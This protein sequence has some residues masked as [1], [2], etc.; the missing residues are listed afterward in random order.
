MSEWLVVGRRRRRA[1]PLR[2]RR[3]GGHLLGAG[4]AGAELEFPGSEMPEPTGTRERVVSGSVSLLLHGGMIALLALAAALAPEEMIEEIIEITRLPDQATEEPAPRPKVLA[5]SSGRFDPAPMAMAPRIVNPAVI[6]RRSNAVEARQLQVDTVS[7]VQ[8]PREITRAAA[9]SVASVR[10]YQSVASATAAPVA[11]DMAAPVLTGPVEVRAPVGQQAGPRQ[12][13]VGNTVGIA[14]PKALGSGSSVREGIASNRDV[15]GGREGVRASVNWGVGAGG[16]R[17]H[18]GEGSGPGGV[19]F[20]ECMSRPEVR[21][22]M[23]QVKDRVVSRWAA[24]GVDGRFKVSLRFQLDPA[25]T[26]TRIQFI[27]GDNPK[28]GDSTV[29]A[30]RSASPFDPMSD[31]VRCLAGTTLLASFILE[32]VEN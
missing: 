8:A 24:P 4:A 22:Y 26:A 32:T 16:G 6:Q 12:V 18:G 11:I 31:Q 3:L 9:P 2:T 5:E 27:S 10:T 30:M 17:G 21:S 20:D 23:S 1:S 29:A 14:D 13:S 7:P 28:V 15:H 25:G 19:S